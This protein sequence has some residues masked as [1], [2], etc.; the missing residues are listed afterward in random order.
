MTVRRATLLWAQVLALAAS[1][2]AAQQGQQL[3]SR[4]I[5][6]ALFRD[7]A[8][9]RFSGQ[10]DA[11]R[12][13]CDEV[14]QLKQRFC[15][16]RTDVRDAAGNQLAEMTVSTGEDG[17]PAALLRMAARQLTEKGIDIIATPPAEKTASG[18]QSKK[19]KAAE[20]A[21]YR[22]YPAGCD[23]GVCQLIWTLQPDQITA[24]NLNTGLTLRYAVQPSGLAAATSTPAAPQIMEA[25]I[26]ST[27][28]AAALADSLKP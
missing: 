23:G 11:W 2:A 8:I 16:L 21:E 3:T 20:A 14:K 6:P 13:V 4:A 18:K 5:D 22:V 1:G 26:V 28:F 7:G 15:S 24:L 25:Q 10:H 19:A 17:R 12:Y 27:G 9:S